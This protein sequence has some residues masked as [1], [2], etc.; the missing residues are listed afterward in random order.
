MPSPL[1][2][3]IALVGILLFF[4]SLLQK[5]IPRFVVQA[6]VGGLLMILAFG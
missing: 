1:Q 5:T 3:V 6:V 4:G 2:S